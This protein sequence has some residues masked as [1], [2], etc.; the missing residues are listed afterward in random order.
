MLAPNTHGSLKMGVKEPLGSHRV[1]Q[2]CYNMGLHANVLH[3]QQQAVPLRMSQFADVLSARA[4][5]VLS[6]ERIG[7]ALLHWLPHFLTDLNK[8]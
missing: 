3:K 2:K 4:L 6:G 8:F 7:Y 1:D 5:E